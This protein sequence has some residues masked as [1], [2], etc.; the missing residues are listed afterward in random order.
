MNQAGLAE[1]VVRAVQSCHP[2]LQPV[3]F[4]R[5]NLLEYLPVYVIECTIHVHICSPFPASS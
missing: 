1:C 3:L 4:E 2:Y 5:Y